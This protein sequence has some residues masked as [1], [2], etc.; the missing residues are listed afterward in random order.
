[1]QNAAKEVVAVQRCCAH[2]SICLAQ[3]LPIA[4][5]VVWLLLLLLLLLLSVLPLTLQ[6]AAEEDIGEE[7]EPEDAEIY[8]T[9][10]CGNVAAVPL[11]GSNSTGIADA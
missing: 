4:D 1:M 9:Y 6:D 8:A 10:R 7:A 2:R 5:T 3:A 11:A